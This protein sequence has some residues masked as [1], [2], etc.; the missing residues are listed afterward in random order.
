MT[1]IILTALSGLGMFLFGMMYMEQSLKEFAGIKFK[2]WIKNSTNT[3]LKALST[4]AIATALL[5]S[6]SVITLMTLSFVSASLISLQG[7]IGLIFGANIGTTA[8]AW[9][10]AILGFKVKIE[11]FALPMIG[12]G[13]IAVMFLRNPKLVATAK[14]FIGFGLL[15]MVDSLILLMTPLTRPNFKT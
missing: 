1:Q 10:V 5:Q 15:F 8:T 7:G 3:D 12:L 11:T 14:V 13:G 4:G 6:S 9:L 2:K